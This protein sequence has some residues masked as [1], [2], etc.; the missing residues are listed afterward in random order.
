L[1]EASNRIANAL[2]GLG[3]EKDDHVAILM[4]HSP[5][6]VNNYFG[7]IKAGGVAVLLSSR[8]KAPELD[9]FLR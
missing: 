7:V 6:W 8:L 3:L 2:I 5:E 1:S 4:S 9:S